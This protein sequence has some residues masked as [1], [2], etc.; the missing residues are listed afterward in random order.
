MGLPVE[1]L[2]E[3]QEICSDAKELEEGG[4]VYVLLPGLT[5]PVGCEPAS[6][7]AL[8]RPHPRDGYSSRLFFAGEI[9]PVQQIT[10]EVLNWNAK[11]IRM[12]ERNWFAYSWRTPEGL[13]LAQMVAIHLKALR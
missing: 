10:K 8:L 6:T 5:L 9:K 2:K 3:L 12:F 13:T 11:S 4:I 7:D 1:Q